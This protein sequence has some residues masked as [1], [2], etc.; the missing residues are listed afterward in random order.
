MKLKAGQ[1]YG[2]TAKELSTGGFSFTEKSYSTDANLPA[3]AHELSHFCLVLN[4]Y[5]SEKIGSKCF[6][7]EPTALVFYP[8]DTSHAETHF[9]NGRHLLVEVHRESLNKIREYGAQLDR[10]EV[11]KGESSLQTAMRMYKEFSQRD[12]YSSLALESI[13]IELL[14]LASR[15]HWKT[16]LAPP[17]WLRHVKDYLHETFSSPPGLKQLARNV[18]VHPTHLARV[19]RKFEGCTAG[20]YVR[21]IRLEKARKAMISTDKTLVEIAL[22]TGFSDQAHF[23]RTFKQATGLTPSAFRKIFN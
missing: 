12:R 22:E 9:S 16:E 8:P 19:F 11:L 1:F 2:E 6:D 4:G 15:R 23:S 14:I 18:Q 21:N 10:P 20:E 13:S 5:Y 17:R 3:H 7:R